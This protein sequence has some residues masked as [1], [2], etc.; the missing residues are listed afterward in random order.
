MYDLRFQ[1][2]DPLDHLPR[3]LDQLRR[4]SMT[5]HRADVEAEADGC[6]RIRV[7]FTAGADGA[8]ETFGSRVRGMVGIT[9]LNLTRSNG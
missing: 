5:L 4:A 2:D 8:A 1:S 6:G 7:L 9:G 3:A